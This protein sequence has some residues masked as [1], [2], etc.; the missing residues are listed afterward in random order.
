MEKDSPSKP[1]VAE[2]AGRLKGHIL[3][4]TTTNNGLPFQRRSTSSLKFQN[5][6]DNEESDKTKPFKIKLKSSPIIGKLQANLAL[7]PTALLPASKNSE[8]KLQ[9]APLAPTTSCGPPSPTLQPPPFSTEE[10]EPAVFDTPPVATPLPSIN[11]SR[12]RLSFKRRPPTRP[13]RRSA[14]EEDGAFALALFPCELFRPT[15]NGEAEQGLVSPAEEAR[16]LEAEEDRDC[17]QTQDKVENADPDDRRDLEEEREDEQTQNLKT[18]DEEQVS[19]PSPTGG[20]GGVEE[21]REEKAEEEQ[22]ADTSQM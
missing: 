7:S 5:Q 11:K 10:E 3:P 22:Q 21:R 9:P 13:H 16:I 17:A 20:I 1:S 8:V 18:I 15:E 14:G 4:M 19:E 12:A 6:K 2:L